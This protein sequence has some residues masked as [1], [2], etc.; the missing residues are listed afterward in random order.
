MT[1]SLSA[2]SA[3]ELMRARADLET[4]C[5]P[6]DFFQKIK[7]LDEKIISEELFTAPHLGFVLDAIVLADFAV[8]LKGARRVRLATQDERHPDGFVE[9]SESTLGI[10]VTEVDREARRRGDEYKA[11][12]PARESVDDWEDR[13]NAIPAELDRVILKKVNKHYHPAPTLVV[14]LNLNDYGI[15]QMQTEA[16]IEAALQRH[17]SSFNGIYIIWKDKLFCSSQMI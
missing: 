5:A 3:E 13:A 9:T 16:A 8:R 7:T 12:V 14:Y 10:E 6:Q 1:S 2:L 15:R 11:G 17:C 4:W